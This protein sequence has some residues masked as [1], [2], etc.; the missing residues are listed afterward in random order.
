MKLG[1]TPAQPNLKKSCAEVTLGG[2]S[3]QETVI[4]NY[5]ISFYYFLS[6]HRDAH[7][8]TEI[9]YGLS[10]FSSSTE[11]PSAAQSAW[12]TACPQFLQN[13]VNS[14]LLWQNYTALGISG[15]VKS[16]CVELHFKI[17]GLYSA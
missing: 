5:W 13:S 14:W 11:N 4:R 8:N 17:Y 7:W 9:P 10:S 6:S 2:V 15:K 16:H 12:D 3:I 1:R